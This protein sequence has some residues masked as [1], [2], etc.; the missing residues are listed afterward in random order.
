MLPQQVICFTVTLGSQV[1]RSIYSI[2][3]VIHITAV[4]VRVF[5]FLC[6]CSVYFYWHLLKICSWCML[7]L[8]FFGGFFLFF[9]WTW[10]I[11]TELIIR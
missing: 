3:S 5:S 2:F 4:V 7:G 1:E 11:R 9:E 8:G 6:M 10:M